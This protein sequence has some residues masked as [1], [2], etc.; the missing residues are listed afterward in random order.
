MKTPSFGNNSG[1]EE[2]YSMFRTN[3]RREKEIDISVSNTMRI[4]DRNWS[5]NKDIELV[6]VGKKE[7]AS[8]NQYI[9]IIIYFSL[10]NE[11]VKYANKMGHK[12]SSQKFKKEGMINKST[13][14]QYLKPRVTGRN[15]QSSINSDLKGSKTFIESHNFERFESHEDMPLMIQEIPVK[16]FDERKQVVFQTK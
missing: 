8:D 1:P 2:H 15:Q 9:L 6:P 3:E 11:L 14:S 16:D 13:I 4:Q 5:S 10:R 7:R 12:K